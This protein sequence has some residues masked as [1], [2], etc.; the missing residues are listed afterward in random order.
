[1]KKLPVSLII[2]TF[3]EE[4]NVCNI[5]KNI[6]LL[7]SKDVVIVDGNSIDKT[8]SYFKDHSNS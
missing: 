4:K 6:A 8:I 1:M 3:N 5:K 7:N 2:P